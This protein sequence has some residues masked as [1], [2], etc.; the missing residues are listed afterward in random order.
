[1]GLDGATPI[2]SSRKQRLDPLALPV[3]FT[4][5][6]AAA[7]ERQRQVEISRERVVVRRAVLGIRMAVKLPLAAFLGV[8]LRVQHGAERKVAVFLEH[9]DTALSV[10]LFEAADSEDAVAEWQLWG[11]VLNRPLL[12]GSA[13]G[14]V[15]DPF[16]R[17]GALR[18]AAPTLRRRRRN[19]IRRRRPSLP[20]R[21]RAAS[22]VEKTVIHRDERE[23]IARN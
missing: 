3:R 19:A 7:D 1:M 14:T 6:D 2:G 17:L 23:I 12:L 8:S 5:N 22:G 18:V 16:R 4:A 11:R 15:H 21:R 10:P 13:D 9:S 20:L